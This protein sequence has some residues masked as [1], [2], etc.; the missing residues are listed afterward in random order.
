ML[1]MNQM[2]YRIVQSFEMVKEQGSALVC[3]K[4]DNANVKKMSK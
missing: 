2:N 4:R 1:T 3:G